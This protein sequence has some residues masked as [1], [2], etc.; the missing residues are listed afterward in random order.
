V[1][2][3][4]PNA[5]CAPDLLDIALHTADVETLNVEPYRKLFDGTIDRLHVCSSCQ[6]HVVISGDAKT[7]KT[8]VHSVWGLLVLSL[9]KFGSGSNESYLHAL[10]DMKEARNLV[11]PVQLYFQGLS[12]PVELQKTRTALALIINIAGLVLIAT[13]LAIRAHRKVLDYFAYSGVLSP[14]V[15]ATGRSTFYS[16]LWILTLFRVG[17]F[18]LASIPIVALGLWELLDHKDMLALWERRQLVLIL[19]LPALVLSF[20]TATL[21]ASIA[22]LKQ[23][24]EML[25]FMYRYAP[26]MA[27]GLGLLV[28][29]GSFLVDSSTA[30][31]VRVCITS[32][33]IVGM[34]P[35]LVAPIIP[36]QA[37]TLVTHALLTLIICVVV[38]RHNA[39][40]F[41]AHL[42]EL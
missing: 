29:A 25:S 37:I 8:E 2:E 15:A 30:A 7:N 13:W 33:P 9:A 20:A 23:R 26:L 38:L 42:E 40:W 6:P 19:W 18:L 22:E 4:P 36:P 34:G 32:L 16:A 28:W 17:A 31:F 24:H 1:G 27:A 14:L 12:E 21:I 5:E 11:G 3:V 41:A 39:R 35:I 10:E